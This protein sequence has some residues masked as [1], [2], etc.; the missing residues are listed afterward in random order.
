M[1]GLAPLQGDIT[2]I[3]LAD[4]CIDT[5]AVSFPVISISGELAPY[6]ESY[7]RTHP[8]VSA[9][10]SKQRALQELEDKGTDPDRIPEYMV[11]NWVV[12]QLRE[13][14]GKVTAYVA[15]VGLDDPPYEITSLSNF[16]GVL[17]TSRDDVS[18]MTRFP[19]LHCRNLG[20]LHRQLD[21][22]LAPASILTSDRPNTAPV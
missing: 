6:A 21:F 14:E 12:S 19:R 4:L 16:R 9:V 7:L 13:L 1:E 8:A 15:V 3:G 2:P 20:S 22:M 18:S 11:H 17:A 10:V 5:L